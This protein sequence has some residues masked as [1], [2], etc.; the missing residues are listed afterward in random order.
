LNIDESGTYALRIDQIAE[1]ERIDIEEI[2]VLTEIEMIEDMN[3]IIIVRNFLIYKKRI[4]FVYA[5]RTYNI[6]IGRNEEEVKEE[7]KEEEP[8][9]SPE[10]P[11]FI[12]SGILASFTNTVKYIF[13]IWNNEN[14]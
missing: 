7:K 12:P 5:F 9:I 6:S 3:T 14:N 2:N 1:E 4:F 8:R 10:K 13:R 11:C